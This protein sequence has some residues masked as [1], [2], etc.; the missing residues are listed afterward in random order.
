VPGGSI[1]TRYVMKL[2]FEQNNQ[3]IAKN[4]TITDDIK[5][6]DLESLDFFNLLMHV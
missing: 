1:G 3:T 2:L 5:I 6:T 4:S